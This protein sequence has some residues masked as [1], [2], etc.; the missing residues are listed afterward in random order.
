DV[1]FGK[2]LGIVL[3]ISESNLYSENA[4][5]NVTY[6]YTTT[7]TD[8]RPVVPTAIGLFQSPRINRRSTVTFTSDFKATPNLVLSLGLIYNAAQLYNSQRTFT[9]TATNRAA[10]VGPAPL[11]NFTAAGTITT[12]PAIVMK[13]GEA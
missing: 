5:T 9:F 2:R 8:Q 1:F 10:V 6:N 7:A 3:N 12:A 4:R 13:P 11:E